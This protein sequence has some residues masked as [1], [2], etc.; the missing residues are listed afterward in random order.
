MRAV[1]VTGRC[2]IIENNNPRSSRLSSFLFRRR[3]IELCVSAIN[4]G[5]AHAVANNEINT[6]S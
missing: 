3:T 4:T 6:N 5:S 2:K 1:D